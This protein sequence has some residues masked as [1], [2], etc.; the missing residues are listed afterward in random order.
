VPEAGL[1]PYSAEPWQIPSQ[2]LIVV[3]A[4]FRTALSLVNE[5]NNSLLPIRWNYSCLPY[6]LDH[7]GHPQDPKIS[8]SFKHLNCYTAQTWGYAILQIVKSPYIKGKFIGFW[9]N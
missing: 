6:L 5:E 2:V 8:T 7:I 9:Y 4:V 3:F 1:E